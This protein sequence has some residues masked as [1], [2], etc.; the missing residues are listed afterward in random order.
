MRFAFAI[1][2]PYT[3]GF[4]TGVNV[5]SVPTNHVKTNINSAICVGV[6]RFTTMMSERLD[7]EPKIASGLNRSTIFAN[8][9]PGPS[10]PSI[11]LA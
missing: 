9:G 3:S 6:S 11:V 5:G 7:G 4:I 1:A 8:T 10:P 2:S